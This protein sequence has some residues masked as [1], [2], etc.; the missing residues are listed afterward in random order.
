[1]AEN[2]NRRPYWTTE[3]AVVRLNVNER[4]FYAE[5]IRQMITD[6]SLTYT[7]L[8]RQLAEEGLMT[9]K[10]EMSAILGR[11][12]SG[13]KADEILRRSL[14]ILKEYQER[15]KPCEKP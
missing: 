15:M 6:N 11:T 5:E 12:R 9:D 8:I 7:W 1:M 10:Y 14:D 13:D 2:S 3:N 4:N